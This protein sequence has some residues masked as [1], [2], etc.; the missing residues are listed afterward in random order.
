MDKKLS[1]NEKKVLKSFLAS[2]LTSNLIGGIF[3]ALQPARCRRSRGSRSAEWPQESTRSCGHPSDPLKFVET[4]DVPLPGANYQGS[5]PPAVNLYRSR[6][7]PGWLAQ[8]TTGFRL[9][10]ASEE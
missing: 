2:E 6:V 4:H 9:V 8:E 3:R 1:S 5:L 10:R 7:R